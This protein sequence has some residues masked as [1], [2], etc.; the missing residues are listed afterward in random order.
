MA[1]N[2]LPDNGFLNCLKHCC[3]GATHL[4]RIVMLMTFCSLV[5]L[6]VYVDDILLA[7]SNIPEMTTLKS[8]LD[9]QFKIKDL[10][11]V[12]YFL[13]L[14]ITSHPSGYLMNQH[15]YASYLLEEFVCSHL[16]LV[17]TPLDLSMKLTLI[18]ET[19]CLIHLLTGDSLGN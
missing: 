15:K 17:S 19:H 5:I 1:S 8:F 10:G 11:W 2:K 6:M 3:P 12:H 9:A 4:A 7:G 14:E 18:L 13:G 16:T